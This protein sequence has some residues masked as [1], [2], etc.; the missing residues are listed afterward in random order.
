MTE[1][2]IKTSEIKFIFTQNEEPKARIKTI[3]EDGSKDESDGFQSFE[4]A[5]R[6]LED[7][8]DNPIYKPPVEPPSDSGNESN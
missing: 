5:K 3:Y 8:V 6:L 7:L 1:S 2:K 4:K